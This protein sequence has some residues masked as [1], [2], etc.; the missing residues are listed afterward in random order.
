MCVCVCVCAAHVAL[1]AWWDQWLFWVGWAACGAYGKTGKRR[2][3]TA[4]IDVLFQE[5]T[6]IAPCRVSL[7]ACSSCLLNWRT[8]H[9][10]HGYMTDAG[11]QVSFSRSGAFFNLLPQ[12]TQAVHFARCLVLIRSGFVTLVLPCSLALSLCFLCTHTLLV[13]PLVNRFPSLS[14]CAFSAHVQYAPM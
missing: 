5:A 9:H 10:V 4:N 8:T 14:F 7:L 12:E 11:I 3:D 13:C 6:L 1:Y 2:Q